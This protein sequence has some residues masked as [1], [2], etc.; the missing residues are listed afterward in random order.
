M[1]L[2]DQKEASTAQAIH[3]EAMR[4]V[5]GDKEREGGWADKR[6]PCS[7]GKEVD[8]I[9]SAM[10]D[11]WRVQAK[12]YMG[13]GGHSESSGEALAVIQVWILMAWSV[14]MDGSAIN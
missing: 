8:V 3:Q 7:Q 12:G 9:L 4:W 2:K 11:L 13:K 5:L 1:G 10:G 6:R 14:E